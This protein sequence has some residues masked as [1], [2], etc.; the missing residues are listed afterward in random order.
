MKASAKVQIYSKRMFLVWLVRFARIFVFLRAQ[1]GLK[2]NKAKYIVKSM[3]LRTLPLSLAGIL[4]G[5]FLGTAH[6]QASAATIIFALLT[7][8]FLQILSNL[9]NELGDFKSGTDAGSHTGR[10]DYSL[11]SGLLTVRDFRR[12]IIAAILCSCLFGTL[13]IWYS[14]GTLLAPQ[15]LALLLLGAAAI[16]AAMRYTLGP[17]PYGYRGWGDLFVFLF[18]GLV[19]VMGGY[20]VVCHT[21]N[22]WL[23]LPASAIGFFSIGVLN[24]NNIRDMATDA[25]TRVTV[26]LK[27]GEHNA[28][29]YHAFLICGGWTLLLLFLALC[30]NSSWQWL[31]LC[32][33]PL[34]IRHLHG[35]W[36]LSGRQLD[37]MLPLLVISTFLLSLF[38]GIPAVL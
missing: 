17:K 19:S 38:L 33:L 27:I 18:F 14:Y 12:L 31:C 35:V 20:F 9:S 25:E 32:L 8:V 28:K 23:L 24:V 22:W 30:A 37:R 7:T 21:L 26:P 34:Y 5:L 15:P 3:R 10:P 36:T 6:S 2:M 11:Q 16:V 4:L 1:I 13:M 29:I